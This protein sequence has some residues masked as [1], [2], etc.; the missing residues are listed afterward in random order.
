MSQEKNPSDPGTNELETLSLCASLAILT[1]VLSQWVFVYQY[2]KVAILMPY[3]L[4]LVDNEEKALMDERK[5]RRNLKVCNFSFIL[6]VTLCIGLNFLGQMDGL[7]ICRRIRPLQGVPYILLAGI[8]SFSMC[9]VS[10][11]TRHPVLRRFNNRKLVYLSVLI[12][13]SY[14]L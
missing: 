9:R 3:I 7:W 1:F 2:L 5:A 12:F 4:G 14:A 10:S 8:L 6:F 13:I 11:F